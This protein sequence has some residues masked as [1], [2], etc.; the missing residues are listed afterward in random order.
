[1]A[2]YHVIPRDSALSAQSLLSDAVFVTHDSYA[3]RKYAYY[4]HQQNGEHYQVIAIETVWTTMTLGELMK[5]PE[6]V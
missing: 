4:L 5:E 2:S 3:A 6:G 1:M